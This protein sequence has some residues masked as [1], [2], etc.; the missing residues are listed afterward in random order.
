MITDETKHI[1]SSIEET[2][3][4]EAIEE[5]T[6]IDAIPEGSPDLNQ[7]LAF[8]QALG[9]KTDDDDDCECGCGR[10]S[11]IV[12]AL[13]GIRSELNSIAFA[14]NKIANK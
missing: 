6:P 14:L 7:L 13:T 3:D 12:E 10:N 2:E 11:E 4:L 1:T 8:A 5:D 9:I